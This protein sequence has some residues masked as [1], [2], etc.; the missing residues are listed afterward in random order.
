[1]M[2]SPLHHL[3]T[4]TPISPKYRLHSFSKNMA[5][6]VPWAFLTMFS[7][8]WIFPNASLSLT[9]ALVHCISVDVGC[10]L[11][12]PWLQLLTS[13]F[14]PR[15]TAILTR[16]SVDRSSATISHLPTLTLGRKHPTIIP[17]SITLNG[18]CW[19]ANQ[20]PQNRQATFTDN[21][22]TK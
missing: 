16:V 5:T 11:R 12:A 8:I 3:H 6:M 14:P 15:S 18:L 20:T 9:W 21:Q 2:F 10:S 19:E 22:L 4:T 17:L 1:M 13:R 7:L